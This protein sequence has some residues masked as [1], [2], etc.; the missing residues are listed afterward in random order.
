[1]TLPTVT[2]VPATQRSVLKAGSGPRIGQGD[3]VRVALAVYD[4]KSRKKVTSTGY[5]GT[6]PQVLTVDA[7]QYLPALVQSINCGQAGS[8]VAVAAPA[9]DAFGASGNAQLGIGAGDAVLFVVDID[10]VLATAKDKATG[11]PKKLPA[12]FPTVT[13]AATGQPTIR[14]P[15]ATQPTTLKIAESKSGSG[16]TVKAGDN[17]TAQYQGVIWRT[18]AVFD[19]SWGRAPA[20]F[21]TD[22]VVKGFGT[23]LIGRKVGSQVVAIIPPAQGYGTAGNAQA[24]I[25]GTDDLVFVIDILATT[26][27]G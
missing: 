16:D 11:T 14:I 8:R 27:A 19:Q 13:L 7:T 12:G 3:S 22:G 2:T 15:A 18:G 25:K 5:G 4:L 23:A 9:A 10:A 26:H 6:N 17:V 1:M 20:N 21:T 24:G